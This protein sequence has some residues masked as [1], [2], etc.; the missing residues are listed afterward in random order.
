[1]LSNVAISNAIVDKYVDKYNS[2]F[3]YLEYI[4]VLYSC[5]IFV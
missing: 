2:I 1:M 3:I 4:F 5:S